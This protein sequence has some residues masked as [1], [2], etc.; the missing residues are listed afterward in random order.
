MN[1]SVKW[2]VDEIDIIRSHQ[3]VSCIAGGMQVNRDTENGG[4][5]AVSGVLMR[6]SCTGSQSAMLQLRVQEV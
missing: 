5:R 1:S 3:D 4:V 6:W 2:V